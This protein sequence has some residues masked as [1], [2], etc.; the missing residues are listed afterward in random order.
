[1]SAIPMS[2]VPIEFVDAL[3]AT[4]ERLLRDIQQLYSRIDRLGNQLARTR[5][6]CDLAEQRFV[7]YIRGVEHQLREL[8]E[9]VSELRDS[10]RP[11]TE[12]QPSF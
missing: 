5:R 9:M 11:E 1:M 3:Q 8:Y 6:D 12:L 4:E 7:A 10:K 2:P